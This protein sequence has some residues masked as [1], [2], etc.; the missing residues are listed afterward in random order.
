MLA[1]VW[2][3]VFDTILKQP[4]TGLWQAS[5]DT[6]FIEWIPDLLVACKPEHENHPSETPSQ[7]MVFVRVAP[8]LLD[9]SLPEHEHIGFD[10]AE[11]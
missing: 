3:K 7:S 10:G 9:L 11:R 1:L 4:Q 6:G 2:D 8:S 5:S